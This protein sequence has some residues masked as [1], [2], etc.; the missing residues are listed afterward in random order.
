[1]LTIVNVLEDLYDLM[2]EAADKAVTQGL[3]S[4]TLREMQR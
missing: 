2:E 1:M 4:T 3:Q